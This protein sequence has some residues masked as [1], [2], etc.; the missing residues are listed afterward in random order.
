MKE[1]KHNFFFTFFQLKHRQH[2]S[3]LHQGHQRHISA[4]DTDDGKYFCISLLLIYIYCV[5]FS[6]FN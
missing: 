1:C 3:K 6:F 4:N 2:I 5:K